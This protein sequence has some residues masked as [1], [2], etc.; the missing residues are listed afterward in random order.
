MPFRVNY[1]PLPFTIIELY[2]AESGV[3]GYYK[4]RADMPG[5]SFLQFPTAFVDVVPDAEG[6]RYE[7]MTLYS[8]LTVLGAFPTEEHV[9]A[10]RSPVF[11]QAVQSEMEAV[12]RTVG[13]VWDKLNYVD[14][15]KCK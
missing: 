5:G 9:Y 7:R 12:A 2:A 11:D 15:S 4:K 13:L 6:S 8:C 1:G 10:T 3:S 14:R